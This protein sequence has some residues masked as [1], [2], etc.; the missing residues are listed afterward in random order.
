MLKTV[1]FTANLV[2]ALDG[3]HPVAI[4]KDEVRPVPSNIADALLADGRAVSPD[5]VAYETKEVTTNVKKPVK[6]A[7]KKAKKKKG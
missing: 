3:V 7:K 5:K 1:K 2:I 4:K 6:K